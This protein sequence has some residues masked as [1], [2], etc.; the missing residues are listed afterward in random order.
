VIKI[1]GGIS[2]TVDDVPLQSFSQRKMYK[3]VMISGI[4]NLVLALGY[5]NQSFTLKVD[6]ISKYIT[7]VWRYMDSMRYTSFCPLYTGDDEGELLID[8]HSGYIKRAVNDW[9]RQGKASPWRYYQNYFYDMWEFYYGRVNDG[10][11]VYK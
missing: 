8:L 6:L 2:I 3:G 9:P 7:R 10:V 1:G 4:P 11:M 5:T